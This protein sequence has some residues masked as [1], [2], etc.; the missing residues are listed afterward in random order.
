[1]LANQP[2]AK[3]RIDPQ[4]AWAVYEPDAKRPW[5]LK[6]AGHLYRRAG[7]GAAWGDL[8]RALPDGPQKTVDRLLKP[9][10]DAA[11]F[12]RQ[13]DEL[14]SASTSID[15]LRAWWLRRMMETPHRLLEKMTLFWHGH[16]AASRGGGES[17]APMRQYLAT[18][19]KHALGRFD[20]MLAEVSCEPAMLTWLGSTANRKAQPSDHLARTLFERFTLGPGN[21]SDEDVREASRAF[22]GWFVL[23]DEARFIP[24]EHDEGVKRVLGRE[25][26]F[27]AED[28][29]R[30][31][32][33]QPSAPAFLVRKLY[34]WLVCETDEPA[35]ELV[36]PLASQLAK[37]Y[38]I[39]RLVET[40]LRSN[41]FFSPAA[42]RRR[43]KCPV[44]FALGILR[45]MEAIVPTEPLGRA[46]SELGQGLYD[47][48]TSRGWPGG[49][50][51]INQATL[52]GRERL[53]RE[54]LQGKGPYGEKVDPA[55]IAARYGAVQA[56]KAGQWLVDLY[57]QGDL[58]AEA[59]A[60]LLA[61]APELPTAGAGDWL[62]RTA[63]AVAALPEFQLA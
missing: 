52:L 28:V 56:G 41:L 46:L 5:D 58:A 33:A 14:E 27:A 36:A 1:M 30:I 32:L 60:K 10:G 18:L 12:N 54:L 48:P 7:F 51:W 39:S 38:D 29:V 17:A 2:A 8:Q 42:Y 21:F 49:K 62:R 61:G 15:A 4:W 23:R 53:A 55:A 3:T 50:H 31:A 57:L 43:I 11:A 34:R 25:G 24:R 9:E 63:Y 6:L 40:V 22:T 20:R 37:D 13:M 59:R 19:R 35:D 45:P 44:E 16:L 47:P 26:K